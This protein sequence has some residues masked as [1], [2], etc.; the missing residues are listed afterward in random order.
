MTEIA[1]RAGAA[2]GSLYMFFPTKPAL[3]QTL[4]TTLADTLT[5]RLD[6]LR[7]STVGWTA[8]A[9][10]DALFDALQLFLTDHPV[11]AVLLDLPGDDAWRQAVRARRRSQIAALFAQAVPNLP[12]GQ[13]ERLAIIVPELMRISMV[14]SGRAALPQ[15]EEVIAELRAM[16]LHHLERPSGGAG[17]Y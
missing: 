10:A 9:T 12:H 1:A 7:L 14:W 8:A 17:R 2:I 6:S 4:L 13:P 15:R 16:L 3:A 11:Y 5:E